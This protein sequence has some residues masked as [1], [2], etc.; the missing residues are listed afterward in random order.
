MNT[1]DNYL[2]LFDLTRYDV[3]K[4]S[5][6]SQGGLSDANKRSASKLTYR[7][8][9]ALAMATG[10]TPGKVF[11][12]LLKAERS[13][14]Y[15]AKVY[16]IKGLI[17]LKENMER[18]LQSMAWQAIGA[19]GL[20]Y[21]LPAYPWDLIDQLISDYQQTSDSPSNKQLQLIS[22]INVMRIWYEGLD[23]IGYD[24]TSKERD[25]NWKFQPVS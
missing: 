4:V 17:E 1:I 21:E 15:Q 7:I 22:L 13:R 20:G 25:H 12:D 16:P 23:T 11:D 2:K 10:Q 6:V 5:G 18:S 24:M 9:Q 19:S 8:L 3:A 14:D